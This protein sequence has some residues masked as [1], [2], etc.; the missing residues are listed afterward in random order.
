MSDQGLSIFDNNEPEEDEPRTAEDAATQVRMLELGL[1]TLDRDVSQLSVQFIRASANVDVA[2][3]AASS[4]PTPQTRDSVARA[5]AGYDRATL[6]LER[7]R[8][9]FASGVVA[10]QEVEDAEI[11]HALAVEDL[12]QAK[13]SQEVLGDLSA[14]ESS[15]AELRTELARAEARS[16]KLAREVALAAARSRHQQALAALEALQERITATRIDAPVAG[17]L[18]DLRVGPGD[19]VA[20][21]S[22]LARLVDL[23]RLVV[24]VQVPSSEMPRLH[25]GSPAQVVISS[26]SEAARAGTIRS[27]EP[28]PAPNGMHRVVV[29]FENRDDQLLAGQPA[30]VSFPSKPS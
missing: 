26:A 12:Q 21:G 20:A 13:R 9:L 10:R 4:I 6:Q 1:N 27:L 15:R 24:A 5:Q 30:E 28:T 22:V 17:T 29:E 25:I 16:E 14:A 3:R 19:V 2:S 8:K 7:V 23:T 18:T 11:A